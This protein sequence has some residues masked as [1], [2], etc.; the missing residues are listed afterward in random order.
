MKGYEG[1]DDL[2]LASESARIECPHC[3]EALDPSQKRELNNKAFWLKEGQTWCKETQQKVGEGRRSRLATFWMEGPAAAYQTWSQL[4]YKLLAAEQEYDRTGSEESLRAVINTDWGLPYLP[5]SASEQRRSDELVARA[6]VWDRKTVPDGVRFIVAA[7]DV[8]GGKNRRFVCQMVGYG[9][10]GERWI[11][12]RFNIRSSLRFDDDG[13]AAQ[14]DPGAFPEDWHIL[15]SDVLNKLY[16]LADGSGRK[17]RVMAMAV[18]HGGED[19]VSNNAYAFWRHC[20]KLRLNKR[21]YLFKGDSQKRQKTINKT[22][23]DN[24]GR[25]DRKAEAR[26]DVPLYLLQTDQLKDRISSCLTRSTP[27]PNYIHF[28]RWMGEWFYE[29]LTYEERGQDGK[30]RKPGKGANE[31]FDLMCYCHALVMIKGYEKIDWN[32]P[33]PWAC[34]WDNN[35]EVYWPDAVPTATAEIETKP[36]PKPQAS[37]KPEP[38]SSSGGNDWLSGGNS[39]GRSGWL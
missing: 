11:I 5:K 27:G 26:G 23:P 25:A 35:P 9:E 3:H 36:T 38:S 7:V 37:P 4:V 29:E 12:D 15:I 13:V 31:A 30:W 33:K 34:D 28:P 10:N 18:D 2:V 20:R 39:G 1:I 21:V 32:R 24:T 16:P 22:F 8:Q 6:E 19:G 17:M 14:I